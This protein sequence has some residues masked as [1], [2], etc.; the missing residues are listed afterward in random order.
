MEHFGASHTT[1]WHGD[2]SELPKYISNGSHHHTSSNPRFLSFLQS[3]KAPRTRQG[4]H[5]CCMQLL[6]VNTPAALS[7]RWD[8]LYV[9]LLH[10]SREQFLME[11]M[12]PHLQGWNKNQ[13]RAQNRSCQKKPEED[14]V[15][16]LSHEFPVLNN[17]QRSKGDL[18]LKRLNSSRVVNRAI[19]DLSHF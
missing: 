10:G 8:S 9:C 17:L 6:S 3:Q 19:L 7:S 12:Y 14:A 2:F 5:N 16:N 11:M 13:D 15:K 18:S 1:T 4:H